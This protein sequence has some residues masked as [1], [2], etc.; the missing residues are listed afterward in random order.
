MLQGTMVCYETES[1]HSS[2]NAREEGR[3]GAACHAV[4]RYTM[5]H[6]Q[7]RKPLFFFACDCLNQSFADFS[8]DFSVIV[9]PVSN[10]LWHAFLVSCLQ[11]LEKQDSH[12]LNSNMSVL[13]M[14]VR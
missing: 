5:T 10:F 13:L 1:F 12:V 6:S 2:L 9:S 8:E 3:R 7:E 11:T 14:C 4:L